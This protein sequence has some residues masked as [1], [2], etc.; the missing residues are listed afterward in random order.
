MKITMENFHQYFPIETTI[1]L[2]NKKIPSALLTSQLADEIAN[3]NIFS[4]FK[5]I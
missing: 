2:K 3:K 5:R 1:T 4:D